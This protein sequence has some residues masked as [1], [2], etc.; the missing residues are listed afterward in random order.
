MNIAQ[1]LVLVINSLLSFEIYVNLTKTLRC[2]ILYPNQ[3]TDSSFVAILSLNKTRD[4]RV[5]NRG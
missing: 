5:R 1:H 4:V 3:I 2:A